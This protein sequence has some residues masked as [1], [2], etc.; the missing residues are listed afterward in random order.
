MIYRLI[1]KGE[2]LMLCPEV[3]W[4]KRDGTFEEQLHSLRLICIGPFA[5]ATHIFVVRGD[6][7]K[8]K[9]RGRGLL[10]ARTGHARSYRRP[11]S[12]FLKHMWILL[13]LAAA[14][15]LFHVTVVSKFAD[16]PQVGRVIKVP[17]YGDGTVCIAADTPKL[18]PRNFTGDT[19]ISV[20]DKRLIGRCIQFR[21]DQDNFLFCYKGN[22]T[23]NSIDI[24]SFSHF[25]RMGD[26]L[27]YIGNPG[28]RCGNG[29]YTLNVSLECDAT[30][31]KFS[32]TIP[33][34]TLD[35]AKCAVQSV[36]RMR[37]ACKIAWL[38]PSK[39]GVHEIKCVAKAVY[40]AGIA[41]VP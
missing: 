7:H 13:S 36:F 37:E 11:I 9:Q 1:G 27:Y 5:R 35:E 14:R 6:H 15:P 17:G 18:V 28:T 34:F 21:R 26:S 16:L 25:Q 24:G 20:L 33:S 23:L 4:R 41:A 38:N 10:N 39:K 32:F 40:D 3:T 8:L 19:Y 30:L 31:S 29:T 12:H 22:S 2:W